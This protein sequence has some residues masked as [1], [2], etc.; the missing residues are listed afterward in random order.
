VCLGVV[1]WGVRALLSFSHVFKI[2][3]GERNFFLAM[4]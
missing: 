2:M 4:E 1:R 3:R